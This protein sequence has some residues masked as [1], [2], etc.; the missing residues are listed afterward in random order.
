MATVDTVLKNHDSD[1]EDLDPEYK[2]YRAME[3][4]NRL[5]QIT[6]KTYCH[7]LLLTVVVACLLIALIC[8][9]PFHISAPD[10]SNFLSWSA[11]AFFV[12]LAFLVCSCNETSSMRFIIILIMSLFYGFSLGFIIALNFQVSARVNSALRGNQF[13]HIYGEDF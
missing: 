1:D 7:C 6:E 12:L 2:K 3:E 9:G 11:L 13:G 4:M 8:I 10:A 5:R